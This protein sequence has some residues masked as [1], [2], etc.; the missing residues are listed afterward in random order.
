[1][2]DKLISVEELQD[3][4]NNKEPVLILDVR[5]S[6]QRQEWQIKESIHIDAYEQLNVGDET[7]LDMVDIPANA[8]VVTVCAAGK[9]SLLASELLRR[10]GIHAYSLEG[11]N[12]L[13]S[14]QWRTF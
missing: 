11:G 9:T 4:L 5:P 3:K 12:N 2:E 8:P 10:K 1:M 6:G 7:A 14:T 13:E